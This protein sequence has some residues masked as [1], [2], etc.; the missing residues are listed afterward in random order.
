MPCFLCMHR[1][2]HCCC[3]IEATAYI[4]F[5]KNQILMFF[6]FL[7]TLY[8]KLALLL[9]CCNFS[10]GYS[11][12]VCLRHISLHFFPKYP[13]KIPKIISTFFKSFFFIFSM[14][15]S[16][17]SAIFGD[18]CINCN[19][20]KYALFQSISIDVFVHP[21]ACLCVYATLLC[22]VLYAKY[23]GFLWSHF[24][25]RFRWELF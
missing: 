15:L 14:L 18:F 9:S 10:H 2:C 7:R 3:Y 21:L 23:T 25:S 6:F 4:L 12:C 20:F 13:K 24:F 5:E 8:S 1:C 17:F 16:S 19:S 11:Y 22:C